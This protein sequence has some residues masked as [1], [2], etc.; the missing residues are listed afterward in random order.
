[1]RAGAAWL[2]LMMSAGGCAYGVTHQTEIVH[3]ERLA[4]VRSVAVAPFRYALHWTG[5]FRDIYESAGL[6]PP[7]VEK[8]EKVEATFLPEGVLMALGYEV[9]GWPAGAGKVEWKDGAPGAES[10][11]A[12]RKIRAAGA[13]AVLLVRGKSNCLKT[14]RCVAEVDMKLVDTESGAV[15]WESRAEGSSLIAQ[16]NEM[17]AAVE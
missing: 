15:I 16:G 12:L 9:K 6:D 2:A 3:P 5:F 17:R 7:Q 4:R 1:M 11:D 10:Y 13:E 14:Y 8:V